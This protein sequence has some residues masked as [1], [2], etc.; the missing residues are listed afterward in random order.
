MADAPKVYEWQ[1]RLSLVL[2]LIF[3][4]R[5]VGGCWIWTGQLDKRGYGRMYIG[6]RKQFVHNL[7]YRLFVGPIPD[8][9]EPDH[10]CGTRACFNSAHLEAVTQAEN[11]RRG[12]QAK[13]T[14]TDIA[15]IRALDEPHTI[16][17]AFFRVHPSTVCDIRNF[18]RWNYDGRSS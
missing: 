2:R 6:G 4:R 18:R 7:A 1:A 17:A 12:R 15:I 9:E 13:L 10:L 5:V 11:T 16:T 3:K 8:K 14:H